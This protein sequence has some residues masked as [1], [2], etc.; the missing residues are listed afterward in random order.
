L[1]SESPPPAPCI[2]YP[3][4]VRGRSNAAQ[5]QVLWRGANPKRR[6]K[7]AGRQGEPL[8]FAKRTPATRSMHIIP[9]ARSGALK[10][11]AGSG[12]VAPKRRAILLAIGALFGRA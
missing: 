5:A 8:G 4:P 12:L 10:R 3:L 7:R 1:R 9:S 11:R 2:L 6:A